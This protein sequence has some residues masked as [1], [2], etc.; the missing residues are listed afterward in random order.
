MQKTDALLDLT[1][2]QTKIDKIFLYDAKD[3]YE[4]ECKYAIE[5]REKVPLKHLKGQKVFIEYSSDMKDVCTVL[6][7]TI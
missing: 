2:H 1:N 7:S 6:N 3:S 5:K 4:L